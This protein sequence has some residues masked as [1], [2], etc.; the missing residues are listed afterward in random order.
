MITLAK[1]LRRLKSCHTRLTTKSVQGERAQRN[2]RAAFLAALNL[3]RQKLD[4]EYPAQRKAKKK[5]FER[6]CFNCL[7]QSGVA[8]PAEAH[9]GVGKSRVCG[10][11]GC[12]CTEYD[13]RAAKGLTAAQKEVV[14]KRS[15]RRRGYEELAQHAHIPMCAMFG[16]KVLT[17]NAKYWVPAWINELPTTI[18]PH[19]TKTDGEK[20]KRDVHF[21]RSL[22]AELAMKRRQGVA[23]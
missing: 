9:I 22:L 15:L 14:K 5:T 12:P 18:G 13:E 21:R 23:L 7:K 17:V 20:A 6:A 8:H 10:E 3:T 16:V 1:A 19:F 2:A 11:L 4:E